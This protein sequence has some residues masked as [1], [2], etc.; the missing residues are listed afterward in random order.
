[1]AKTIDEIRRDLAKKP[2]ERSILIERDAVDEANR[3]V[4]LAFASDKPVEH[5]FGTLSLSMKPGAMRT[6]RLKNGAPLLMDHNSR[7]QVGVVEEY[8]IDQ[9]D[10]MARAVVRFDTDQRSTDIF[11]SVKNNIR[12]NVSVGFMVNSLELVEEK[13]GEMPAYRCDDWEPME[14]SIVS[15]PA[16]TSVGVGRSKDTAGENPEKLLNDSPI[17]RGK[18][19]Q[20][21][22]MTPEEIAAAAAAEAQRTAAP[23]APVVDTRSADAE[24]VQRTQAIVA[25]AEIFG[26]A[27]LA[28]TMIAASADVTLDD[29]RVA[30]RAKQPPTVQIPAEPAAAAATRQGAPTQHIEL[31]HSV[32]RG[33]ELKAFKGEKALERAHKVGMHL[34]AVLLRDDK[35]IAWCRER[36][37]ALTRAQSGNDNTAGGFTV[38]PEFEQTLFQLIIQY[39]MLR[40]NADVVPMKSDTK[41]VTR[42][43]GRTYGLPGRSRPAGNIFEPRPTISSSWSPESGWC[44]QNTRTSSAKTVSSTGQTVS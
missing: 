23:A 44:S 17:E 24:I 21:T 15:M 3:T 10:G 19:T 34:A 30:I 16:D 37:I 32:Y 5:W 43:K 12:R 4:S 11:N 7:D 27:D 25:F 41:V 38:I 33:G 42:R 9:K 18:S 22:I 6:D 14:I 40:P 39:G 13:K 1:M 20:E 8:S 31:A 2:L 36:G 35:A 28:R 29:V 26:Q